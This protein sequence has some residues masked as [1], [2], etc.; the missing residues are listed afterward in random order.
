MSVITWPKSY[1]PFTSAMTWDLSV[2]TRGST[3]AVAAATAGLAVWASAVAG[4]W[5]AW[6]TAAATATATPVAANQR[7]VFRVMQT[8]DLERDVRQ[9]P[10]GRGQAD[11]GIVAGRGRAAAAAVDR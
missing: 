6:G 9:L 7:N 11:Y 10:R 3:G 8:S 1:I 5:P 4:R 2:A